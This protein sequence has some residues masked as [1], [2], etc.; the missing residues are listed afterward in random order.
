VNLNLL[1]TLVFTVLVPG[2][3]GFYVPYRLRGG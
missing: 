3:V 1:K 2:T